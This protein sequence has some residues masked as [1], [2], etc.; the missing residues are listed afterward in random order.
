MNFDHAFAALTGHPPFP[1]QRR[2]FRR[3]VGETHDGE[4]FPACSLPT[5]LGKTSVMAVWLLALAA[6]ADNAERGRLRGG[7][8]RGD[9]PRRLAYV[10]NRRT[11][12]DQA[13]REAVKLRENLKKPELHEVRERLARLRGEQ[14]SPG[15]TGKSGAGIRTGKPTEDGENETP[16][17]ISTLRGQFAD[18]GE[19]AADPARPAIIVGT[20]DMIGS[21]LLFSGYGVGLKRKPM[22]AGFLGQD[23]L[24]VHDEAHLEPAFQQLIERICCEQR[25]G[26][27]SADGQCDL[28]GNPPPRDY[29]PMYVMPLTATP[30]KG[31]E[32]FKLEQEDREHAVIKRRL[33]AKKT[34][35]LH[36]IDDEKKTAEE[37]AA[38]AVKRAEAS[39]PTPGAAILVFVRKV[40][41]VKKVVDAIG[42]TRGIDRDTQIEQLTGTLRGLERDALVQKPVFQRFLPE[43]NRDNGITLPERTV[44][45]V[46][47]SAGEV[48]VDISADH[49]VCDLTTFDSMA[50][51]FGRVNRYGAPPNNAIIDVV[52]PKLDDF[53]KDDPYDDRRKRTL[54]LLKELDGNCSPKALGKLPLEDRIAAFSPEPMFL[55]ATDILFDAWALTTIRE[56][57]PGRPSVA[58][59][60]HGVPTE[61]RPPETTIAWRNEVQWITGDLLKEY[62]PDDLLD[63]YPIKPHE[64]LKDRSKRVFEE[65]KQIAKRFGGDRDGS[66]RVEVPVWI[67]DDQGVAA[68]TLQ[69]LADGDEDAIAER[70]VILPPFAGGLSASAMLDGKAVFAEGQP[71]D[72]ADA[73]FDED[74]RKRRARVWDGENKGDA[75]AGMRP[76]RPAIDL[77][78]TAAENQSAAADDGEPEVDADEQESQEPDYS[79][80]PGRLWAWYALPRSADDDGSRAAR[81]PVTLDV[82]GRDVRCHAERIVTALGLADTPEGRAVV[83]AAETHDLGKDR[84]P[85]QRSIW[86]NKY[87]EDVVWAKSGHRRPPCDLSTYRHEFGSVLDVLSPPEKYRN[88][89]AKW[90]A[91]AEFERDLALHII[92]AHHGRARPHFPRDEAFDQA[93]GR[94]SLAAK[95]ARDVPGRFGRL[96]RRY[97]R[98]GL[99][100]LESILRA[101]DAAASAAPSETVTSEDHDAVAL[102]AGGVR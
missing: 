96:Q 73:W 100:Y 79:E 54:A 30:R 24:L 36:R 23:T 92:A 93:A 51:R 98:W 84:G 55:D 74:G 32:P 57:M 29:R 15:G 26:R 95:V 71:Y 70:T 65:L 2:L 38:L 19:W 16:L 87:S 21:R 45:L 8:G 18:N 22:H 7:D 60:L 72:V 25:G 68:T 50:Q 27:M 4:R 20:V 77:D 28:S 34:I 56:R 3:F 6:S 52:H 81:E 90:D 31:E 89:K 88:L 11:I 63:V 69:K 35:E 9:V 17:A 58:D 5:G 46:C 101:A 83:F 44:F 12:V 59:W 61:W 41:D 43:S 47:T 1:W 10:V 85:W 76:V 48:G 99:A 102:G 67:E 66:G 64:T 42:K 78:P 40:E 14:A 49:L 82:H 91:L 37:V 39:P 13:T 80:P 53:K 33:E 86:N 62:R 97:G 94:S 75:V